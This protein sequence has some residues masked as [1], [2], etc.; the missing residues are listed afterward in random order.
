MVR[1]ESTA[2]RQPLQRH[3]MRGAVRMCRPHGHMCLCARP[4]AKSRVHSVGA[5]H[6]HQLCC[7]AKQPSTIQQTVQ[8]I[9]PPCSANHET[10][11]PAYR[12]CGNNC[13]KLLTRPWPTCCLVAHCLPALH[14]SGS[15]WSTRA[16]CLLQDTFRHA[17]VS[18]HMPHATCQLDTAGAHSSSSKLS[19][20]RVRSAVHSGSSSMGSAHSSSSNMGARSTLSTALVPSSPQTTRYSLSRRR[21]STG[22]STCRN[23]CDASAA[24]GWPI[25]SGSAIGSVLSRLYS[26]CNASA[27]RSAGCTQ[28]THTDAW[29]SRGTLILAAA[30]SGGTGECLWCNTS[31]ES[32]GS[33]A[34]EEH[35]CHS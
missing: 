30:A 15:T 3:I 22:E 31:G 6:I 1:Q 10:L 2:A 23:C 29:L 26:A 8:T 4:C 9:Q 24:A 25:A 16:L 12:R 21:A 7:V 34:R 33:S 17:P 14:A 32:A 28:Q 18:C 5:Q 19:C 13:N 35:V 11:P 27:A 20:S